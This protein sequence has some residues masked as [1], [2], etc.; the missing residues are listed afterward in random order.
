MYLRAGMCDHI[1]NVL[2]SS[3]TVPQQFLNSSSTVPQEG[4]PTYHRT[5]FYVT[6]RKQ[7]GTIA[8]TYCSKAF[9]D[10]WIPCRQA[11]V[12]AHTDVS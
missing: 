9:F 3:S 6:P 7:V 2:N 1:E 12:S 8:D 4:L 11:L 5:D 10:S